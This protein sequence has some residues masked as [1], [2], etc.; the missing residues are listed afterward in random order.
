MHGFAIVQALEK[1]SKTGVGMQIGRQPIR[2][3]RRH[4]GRDA[5]LQRGEQEIA[6]SSRQPF[7][8]DSLRRESTAAPVMINGAPSVSRTMS[9]GVRCSRLWAIPLGR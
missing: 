7:A 4:G 2:M 1:R 5:A 6:S 9:S 3:Q 8:A